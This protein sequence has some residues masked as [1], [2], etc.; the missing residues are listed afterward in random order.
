M[1]PTVIRLDT[2]RQLRISRRPEDC[3]PYRG[4]DIVDF[5]FW[6]RT[7]NGF[8]PTNQGVAFDAALLPRALAAL[9]AAATKPEVQ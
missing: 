7:K 3:K 1:I 2:K 9:D 6:H 5:R 8:R 4:R